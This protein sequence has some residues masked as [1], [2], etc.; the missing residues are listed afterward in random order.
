MAAPA[1]LKFVPNPP[2]PPMPIGG[3]CGP[4]Q[5][6]LFFRTDNEGVL[7]AKKICGECPIK[8]QCLEYA[9]A[10][11]EFGIWG[12]MTPAER[13]K[14]RGFKLPDAE[15]LSRSNQA[16]AMLREGRTVAYVAEQFKVVER[17]VQRFKRAW[18]DYEAKADGLKQ[19]LQQNE[20][21]AS[22][23]SA[24]LQFSQTAS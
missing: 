2:V 14:V 21:L 1:R 3:A 18:L 5:S 15:L 4:E 9:I 17:T 16:V 24:M 23:E 19:G 11:E 20:L 8:R 10:K 7:F 13:E 6:D 12:G 22:S